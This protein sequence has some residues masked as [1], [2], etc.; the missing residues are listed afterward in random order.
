MM[1]TRF[2]NPLTSHQNAYLRSAAEKAFPKEACGFFLFN[3]GMIEVQNQSTIPEQFVISAKDYAVYDEQIAAIW[4]THARYPRF[5]AAD[6]QSCKSLGIP[7]AMWD[8]S[9]S[10]SY[11]LDTNQ[12]TGLIGRP[13]NYGIWDCY[14]S[15]RDWYWQEFGISLGDYPRTEEGEWRNPNF[16]HFE[17]NFR[18]EG[19]E[20]VPMNEA[21]RGDV[22]LM[23]IRNDNTCNHVAV[24][25]D[26]EEGLIYH[27]AVDRLSEVVVYGHWMRQNTYC[28]VRRKQC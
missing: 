6:I 24:I 26:P 8:C 17:D 23:R 19:F 1:L 15:V 12:Y 11:W 27:H 18:R 21:K 25:E 7:F 3:G 14:A 22:L 2:V 13:W 10:Q 4:H 16:T 20:T 28:I 5:S 9:S